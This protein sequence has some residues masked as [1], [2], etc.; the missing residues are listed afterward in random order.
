MVGETIK[1][2][3]D[4][5]F[6]L[7]YNSTGIDLSAPIRFLCTNSSTIEAIKISIS[8]SIDAMQTGIITN[9]V[10]PT[11]RWSTAVSITLVTAILYA[12]Y[13]YNAYSYFKA[14]WFAQPGVLASL[15]EGALAPA[16]EQIYML[17]M[18][19]RFSFMTTV[20]TNLI[21]FYTAY[22]GNG[23]YISQLFY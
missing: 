13:G 16:N 7:V 5:T 23:G 11:V 6:Q 4:K 9:I 17:K 20:I 22:T 2:Y 14:D 15:S 21:T 12:V 10:E 19:R 8:A 3:S 18:L 1:Y